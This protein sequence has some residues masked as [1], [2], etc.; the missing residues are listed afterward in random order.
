MDGLVPKDRPNLDSRGLTPAETENLSVSDQG[1]H[2]AQEL[3]DLYFAADNY[4]VALEYYRRALDA[5]ARKNGSV[6]RDALFRLGARIV[7]CLRYRGDLDEAVDALHDL[8]HRLRPHVTPEQTG[9][10]AG[11]LGILLFDRARYRA[12]QRASVLA[13]RLLRET[14]LNFDIGRA[15]M[16]LGWIALRTGSWASARD[17]F[18]SAIA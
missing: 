3:G 14:T 10:L 8:H 4:A 9:R 6:D 15:E 13:Y 16:T 11:S 12:A 1:E 17:Y 18:E 5:E 2:R 7:D